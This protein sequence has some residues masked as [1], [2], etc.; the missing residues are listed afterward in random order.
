MISFLGFLLL[1]CAM[2]TLGGV[3][4]IGGGLI[5]IPVLILVFD[6]DQQLAQ[7]T[8][9]LMVVPNVLLA[10]WRYNQRAKVNWR[11]AIPLGASGMVAGALGSVVAAGLDPA[12]MSIGFAL[13]MLVLAAYN[14]L[15]MR[16]PKREPAGQ[17]RFGWPA[18]MALGGSSGVLGGFFGVG[19]SV[20]A[21]P[22]LTSVFAASQVTAQS[23]SLA[24]AVP[25]TGATL[26]TY[27]LHGHV[28]WRVGIPLSIGGLMSVSWGVGVAHR[29]PEK[30]LRLLFCLF[31]VLCAALLLIKH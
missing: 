28:D 31:L 9:L 7:G 26:V 8:V 10:L 23:L 12:S 16:I 20:L 22:V 1:G 2:G 3:F 6:V 30:Q 29:M 11:A 5:A 21:T 27:A 25:T 17:L 14:F 4:G 19:G 15:Q 24:L 18:L 13:F